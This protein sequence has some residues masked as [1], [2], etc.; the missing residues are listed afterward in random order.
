[1][2]S[3]EVIDYLKQQAARKARQRRKT[4]CV[5]DGPEAVEDW[6]PFPFP[7]LTN[8]FLLPRTEAELL[9]LPKEIFDTAEEIGAAGWV[10]D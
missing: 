6:P 9:A 3:L 10:V 8:L 2:W 7:S 4:P 5:P 1:M